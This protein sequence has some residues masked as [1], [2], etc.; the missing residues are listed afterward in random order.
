MRYIKPF[1]QSHAP[2]PISSFLTLCVCVYVSLPPFTT[3]QSG[4]FPGQ[5]EKEARSA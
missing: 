1:S 5:K 4:T 3:I 2:I